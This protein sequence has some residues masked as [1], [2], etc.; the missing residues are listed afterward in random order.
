MG[1]SMLA[2]LVAP[3]PVDGFVDAQ[4]ARRS[5][6]LRGE[7]SRFD[8]LR[9]AAGWEAWI[10]QADPVDAAQ[11]D[12]AGGQIQQR[13]EPARAP[14]AFAAGCTIC[15]DVSRVAA[16]AELLAG[17]HAD[18]R[19]FRGEPFAKL[20]VSPRGAGFAPH[21]DGHH[22]FVMQLAGRKHW[23]YGATPARPGSLSGGKVDAQG[24]PVHTYPRDGLP[25][26]DPQGAPLP[27]PDL[28]RLEQTDLQPGDV[29]YLP[30]GT[31]HTTEALETSVALSVSPP[32]AAIADLLADAVRESLEAD[33][34]L[35]TDIVAPPGTDGHGP[36]RTVERAVRFGL[37][38]LR[39][40]VERMHVVDLHLRWAR[41]VFAGMAPG[42]EDPG[43][44]REIGP[45]DR[46]VHAP[47]GFVWMRAK[48]PRSRSDVVLVFRPGLELVLPV[49]AERFV[50]RLHATPELTL[51]RACAFEPAWAP[52]DVA[53]LLADLAAAGVLVRA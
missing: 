51:E 52:G 13:I 18:L 42:A 43:S 6:H 3:L 16:V 5:I 19:P 32:R 21:I 31:W 47:G 44:D 9:P 22:V 4:W 17:L 27:A 50:K 1:A 40:A 48:D 49:H 12:A 20:Y 11:R 24:Q 25:M 28:A 34:R 14:E 2:R 15:A 35:W 23:R 46:L 41:E 53:D 26:L 38:R 36:P 29:L 39:E 30:P 10:G 45:G 37:G 8:E 7:A 33:P